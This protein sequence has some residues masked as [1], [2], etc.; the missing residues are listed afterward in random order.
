MSAVKPFHH[1]SSVKQIARLRKYQVSGLRDLK[2]ALKKTK[3]KVQGDILEGAAS[4]AIHTAR[5]QNGVY[6]SIAGRY[7]QLSVD[8]GEWAKTMTGEVTRDWKAYAIGEIMEQS[9]SGS[10]KSRITK[11][12]PQY[13]ERIFQL[14]APEGGKRFAGIFTDKMA[15]EDLQSLREATS[16]AYRLGSLEGWTSNRI[17]KEIQERWQ[18]LAVNI[19]TRG[20][21]DNAN[22]RWDNSAY[23]RML[24]RTTTARVARES[25]LTTLTDNGDDLIRVSSVGDS[26][27]Y[28]VAWDGVILS[29]SGKDNRFPSYQQAVNS[30][31]HLYGPNCDCLQ[32]RVDQDLN[33]DEIKAQRVTK[34][35]DWDSTESIHAFKDEASKKG[36]VFGPI[37]EPGSKEAKTPSLFVT[38]D[39][40]NVPGKDGKGPQ[41][42]PV[43][44][45]KV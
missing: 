23:L 21:V 35:A 1:P 44:V 37:L 16:E 27:P 19:G 8:M 6:R 15:Q 22:R 26:C 39:P 17:Q 43:Q 5:G 18:K 29:I 24:T 30:K 45:P 9:G 28:C 13:A 14:I 3:K 11:F 25:Y 41:K 34:Q 33:G 36:P 20:F 2:A 31:G 40:R 4:G 12:S 42:P 10:V 32:V 38:P 7:S